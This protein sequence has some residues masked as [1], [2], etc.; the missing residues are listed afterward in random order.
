[1]CLL[2]RG[3]GR[4]YFIEERLVSPSNLNSKSN[5]HIP[6]PVI[7]LLSHFMF[8]NVNASHPFI[9]NY[10]IKNSQ[11]LTYECIICVQR[12]GLGYM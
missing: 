5:V 12:M 1:M 11:V 2:E 9:Q 4:E 7:F 3:Q 8:I 10:G 6:C